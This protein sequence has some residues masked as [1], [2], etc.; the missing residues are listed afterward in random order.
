MSCT[1]FLNRLSS[2]PGNLYWELYLNSVWS[3]N[4]KMI[5]NSQWASIHWHCSMAIFQCQKSGLP[6]ITREAHKCLRDHRWQSRY[7]WRCKICIRVFPR[8]RMSGDNHSIAKNVR[9]S[10][11]LPRSHVTIAVLPRRQ[12]RLTSGFAITED[13]FR[14]KIHWK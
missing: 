13:D 9:G 3:S 7:H 11:V 10:Q 1:Q 5:A 14:F 6:E 2:R 8:S 4:Y 12:G